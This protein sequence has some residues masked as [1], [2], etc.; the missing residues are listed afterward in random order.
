MNATA[1][2]IDQQRRSYASACVS[3]ASGVRTAR[4]MKDALTAAAREPVPG[5]LLRGMRSL[6]HADRTRAMR[7]IEDELI[8]R[9]EAIKD[10][11]EIARYQ[12]LALRLINLPKVAQWARSHRQ[13]APA[14]R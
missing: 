3:W 14:R 7:Q 10:P 4:T 12:P 2:L 8:V 11:A 5:H 9:L 13:G 6:S 1:F